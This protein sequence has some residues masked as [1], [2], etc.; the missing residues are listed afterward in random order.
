MHRTL[1][2]LVLAAA[3]TTA[4]AADLKTNIVVAHNAARAAAG[5]PPIVWSDTLA[6]DAAPWAAALA[7]SERWDVLVC[8]YSRAGNRV[9]EAVF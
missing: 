7:H 8:R 5:T 1:A 3:G 4:S 2:V 9:G 6:A